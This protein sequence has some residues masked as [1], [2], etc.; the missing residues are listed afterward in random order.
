MDS[1]LILILVFVASCVLVFL[2]M[3]GIS[4][5]L[6]WVMNKYN[7]GRSGT[8]TTTTNNTAT[9]TTTT[10]TTSQQPHVSIPILEAR[11]QRPKDA[12]DI[13][14][15]CLVI[16]PHEGRRSAVNNGTTITD[17]AIGMKTTSTG[18]KR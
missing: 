17:Y 9:T 5:A 7:L 3:A 8:A 16:L 15:T 12:S 6:N 2:L 18:G 4:W 11:A 13:E 1:L 10:M 14:S